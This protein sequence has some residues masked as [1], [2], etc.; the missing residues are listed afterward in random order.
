MCRLL[1]TYFDCLHT[2][3]NTMLILMWPVICIYICI[4]IHIYIHIHTHLYIH[5]KISI[6]LNSKIWI[7]F[8]GHQDVFW[9]RVQFRLRYL[10]FFEDILLGLGVCFS[11]QSYLIFS[12]YAFRCS[13]TNR[14][15][16]AKDRR[17][18]PIIPHPLSGHPCCRS[19]VLSS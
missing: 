11:V 12:A 2:S 19:M 3:I 5:R 18:L 17:E 16:P 6:Y 13:A 10:Y 7:R 4:Y 1:F 8:S 9:V 14:L 15:I